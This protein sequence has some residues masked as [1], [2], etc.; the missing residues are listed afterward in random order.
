M[1][2]EGLNS[3]PVFATDLNMI[4]KKC[5]TDGDDR[6]SRLNDAQE[7]GRRE[8]SAGLKF[9]MEPTEWCQN[10]FKANVKTLKQKDIQMGKNKATKGTIWRMEPAAPLLE[11]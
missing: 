1:Q 3:A 2:E 10:V 5:Q 8:D 9:Q 6:L 7:K 11:V 4:S